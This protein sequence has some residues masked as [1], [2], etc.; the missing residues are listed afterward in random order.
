MAPLI[1]NVEPDLPALI[2][3]VAARCRERAIALNQTKLVKLLYLVDV[4]RVASRRDALTGLHWVFFHYGPYAL[5]LLETVDETAGTRRIGRTWSQ[6]ALSEAAADAP[7]G[8]DWLSSTRR[9]VDRVIDRFAPME[10]NELLDH[11]YFQT[12]PMIGAKRGDPLDLARARDHVEPRRR[13]PLAPAA[14]PDDVPARLASW[15]AQTRRR[16]VPVRLD[17]AGRFFDDA[18]E[19]A[20]PTGVT[21][22]VSVIDE[23]GL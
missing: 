19:D 14:A 3:Y 12:A 1:Q 5:E 6:S 10:L 4:A 2:A 21:G 23:S 7:D 22:A 13:T 8:E 20:A 11:V 17:P 16:L 18:G 9:T 15:R